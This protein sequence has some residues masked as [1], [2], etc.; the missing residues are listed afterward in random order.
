MRLEG[1]VLL[2]KCG[3]EDMIELLFQKW[4][5]RLISSEANLLG[6]PWFLGGMLCLKGPNVTSR[7]LDVELWKSRQ[8]RE[9]GKWEGTY[10]VSDNRWVGII[11]FRAIDYDL[12]YQKL[13]RPES[14]LDRGGVDGRGVCRSVSTGQRLNCVSRRLVVEE[15]G[16]KKK[17]I[18]QSEKRKKHN[19]GCFNWCLTEGVG[20]L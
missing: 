4:D 13:F 20:W 16:E 7:Y 6:F 2:T 8:S 9:S 19:E 15:F 11:E 17:T 1:L 5:D 18:N 3:V 14:R 10:W 12:I